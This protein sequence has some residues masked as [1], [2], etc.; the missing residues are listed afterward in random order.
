MAGTHFAAK[1]LAHHLLA[2]ADAK[3]RQPAIEQDLRC[4]RAVLV[5]NARRRTGK[6]DPLGLQ[7]MK[8][9]L[10]L[11]ERR[12]LGIDPRLAHAAC[13]KLGD[14][15]AEIDNE[16]GIGEVLWLHAVR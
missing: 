16:Y 6:D 14:L 4:A 2:V 12:D 15:A 1:L 13:D 9:F 7:A 8:G 11:R 3:D 10:G 5:A